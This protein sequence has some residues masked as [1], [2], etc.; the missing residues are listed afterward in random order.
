MKLY[1]FIRKKSFR[2][3]YTL[4]S[5]LNLNRKGGIKLHLG[6]GRD[7]L[8]EYVNIDAD[9]DALCDIKTD[10][11]N[12]CNYFKPAT[13]EEILMIHSISYLNLWEARLFFNNAFQIL[14]P[15]GKLI[16]ELPSIEKCAAHLI[17]HKDDID[18]YVEGV[19]GI[20]AFDLDMINN[21]K[22]YHPYAFGWS[23]WHIEHEL[24]T[25]GFTDVKIMEPQTHGNPW[26]DIRIEAI[27]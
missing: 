14:Q 19:R 4:K 7:Y 2:V 3:I 10:Y 6:S 5:V 26:R 16:M 23:G 1:P 12:I 13:V 8:K 18:A 15:G 21:K 22:K 17:K 24:R 25:A 9:S 27:R 20:Y 11:K